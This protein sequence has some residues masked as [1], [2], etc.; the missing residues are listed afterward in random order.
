MTVQVDAGGHAT[1]HTAVAS[2]YRCC[3]SFVAVVRISRRQHLRYFVCALG[4]RFLLPRVSTDRTWQ[5]GT[6][7]SDYS[8]GAS[9]AVD[10]SF[11]AAGATYGSWNGTTA[12]YFD[13]LVIKINSDREVLWAW[14]VGKPGGGRG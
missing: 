3:V 4:V 9:T 13:F 5:D 12:G 6:T 11:Y 14:Q 2:V 1:V 10:G 8:W 7:S